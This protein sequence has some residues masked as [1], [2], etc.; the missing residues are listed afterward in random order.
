[1]Y[2][3][4]GDGVEGMKSKAPFA[5]ESSSTEEGMILK[6]TLTEEILQTSKSVSVF[7]FAALDALE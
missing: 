1:M 3:W 6:V 4:N 7:C 5:Q 2:G